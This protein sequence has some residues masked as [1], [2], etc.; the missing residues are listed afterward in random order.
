VSRKVFG[1]ERKE[2]AEDWRR[3]H[4]EELDGSYRLPSI[5]VIW[6]REACGTDGRGEKCAN[7]GDGGDD[8]DGGKTEGRTLV[9][10][11]S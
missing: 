7:D 6:S 2:M 11:G 9:F 8:D 10:M 3:L 1:P 5:R 4:N